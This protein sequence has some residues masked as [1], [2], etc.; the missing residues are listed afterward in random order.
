MNYGVNAENTP[1]SLIK[2]IQ[3]YIDSHEIN[4]EENTIYI[5]CTDSKGRYLKTYI[6]EKS[7]DKFIWWYKGGRR[8]ED[9]IKYINDNLTTIIK[10]YPT[11]KIKLIFWHGTCD[12]TYKSAD[13]LIYLRHK[14]DNELGQLFHTC[15][16]R[17]TTLVEAHKNVT[18]YLLEIPPISTKM[19]NS[20]HGDENWYY[21]DDTNI[22]KQV[23][24]HNTIVQ[25]VNE[26]QNFFSP[27]FSQDFKDS[28]K[29]SHSTPNIYYYDFRISKDGVHPI[30]ILAN[31]W[32][33]RIMENTSK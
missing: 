6:P 21:I 29:Y 27:Q 11:A 32:A 24:I 15:Y 5:I 19:W 25:R 28:K 14:D 20:Q 33:I 16:N 13:N 2:K 23:E 10:Q 8:T 26:K 31:K 3:R 17:L 9:G 12:I 30:N 22:N 7:I 1:Q 18:L 4:T